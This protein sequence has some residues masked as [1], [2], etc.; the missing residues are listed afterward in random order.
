MAGLVA[1]RRLESAGATV[2]V[3]DKGRS[4]GGRMA[5][6]RIGTARLDHGAQF[7]TA[8]SDTFAAM[9]ADWIDAGVAHEWCRG[10]GEADGHARYAGIGGM[11]S[12]AKHMAI[13][14]DVRCGQ[15]AFSLRRDDA[16]WTLVTDDGHEHL[17]DRVV[18]T[19]PVPQSMSL[20]FSAGVEL[21]D[22][23][24]TLDYDRTIGLLV[25]LDDSG[26]AVAPPGGMQSPDDVFSFVADNRAKGA[27]DA[28]ALT[29]HASGQW[30]LANY[31]I[32][33]DTLAA[34]LLEAA[35]PYL[36]TARVLEHQVKK[37]R[38]ATPRTTWPERCWID[39]TGTLAMAGDAFAGP[40]V[41]GAALSGLAAAESLL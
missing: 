16:G 24:R 31:D 23:L 14:L 20:L 12:I 7:F 4:V 26:H 15:L 17:A 13:G 21:P 22:D 6:R 5:T 34:L 35:S 27:S 18:L 40:R 36:G 41:E 2:T 32:D 29:L 8:R 10:F 19:A 28:P 1:A 11:T 9:V 33:N 25:A 39:P 38:F 3:F 37:W 30:S